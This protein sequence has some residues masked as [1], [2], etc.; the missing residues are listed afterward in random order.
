M[1][2]IERVMQKY[3]KGRNH[4]QPESKKIIKDTSSRGPFMFNT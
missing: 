1:K 2:K 3:S 4:G